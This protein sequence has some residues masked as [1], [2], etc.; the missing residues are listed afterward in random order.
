MSPR[1]IPLEQ[2]EAPLERIPDSSYAWVPLE[3]IRENGENPRKKLDAVQLAELVESVRRHGILQPVLV[4]P[5][6]GGTTERPLYELV[7]GHRRFAAA[8]VVGLTTL[9]ATVRELSESDV[10]E[11]VLIENL[12]RADLSPL[13]EARGYQ[14]LAK[15]P[16]YDVAKIAARVGRSVEYVYARMKLLQLGKDAQALLAAGE[17]TAGHAI[18]LARLSPADQA[19]A[20]K[21]GA[22]LEQED[23]R[24]TEHEGRRMKAV[25]VRELKGWIDRNVRM[26]PANVDPMLFPESA[27]ALEN[28][29]KVVGITSL[30]YVPEEAR[31]GKTYFP[32]SWK[33]ADGREDSKTCEHATLGFVVVGP[34]RGEAFEV[35]IAKDKCRTHWGAEIRQREKRAKERAGRP[36]PAVAAAKE[37]KGESPAEAK[38]SKALAAAVEAASERADEEIDKLFRERVGAM[39][40]EKFLRAM[41]NFRGPYQFTWALRNAGEKVSGDAGVRRW[42][43]T[44]PLG[45]IQVLVAQEATDGD[46]SQKDYKVLGIDV[47]GIRKRHEAEAREAHRVQTSATP[48]KAAAP[49]KAKAAGGRRAKV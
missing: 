29:P 16:G 31:E 9:P 13:E 48:A 18:L 42:F 10:L 22:G 36:G 4:R 28:A 33:R 34:R 44:A 25:S 32:Q 37:K 46:M 15:M 12:Q 2:V 39:S 5:I 3:S 19:R 26:D 23:L 38:A 47:A 6:A 21:E 7:A 27:L 35:C 24:F 1:E 11:I 14:R 45:Q 43:E 49:R 41:V 40:P 20:L 17:L 30:H 8:K